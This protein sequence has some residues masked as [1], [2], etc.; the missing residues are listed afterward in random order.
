MSEE[1][2]F[3]LRTS[4]SLPRNTLP[5][6]GAATP[7]RE[8]PVARLLSASKRLCVIVAAASLFSFFAG[9]QPSF[10]QVDVT[11]YHYDNLRTGWNNAETTLTTS[12]VAAH[13]GASQSFNLLHSVALDEQVDAQPL[14]VSD[15]SIAGQSGTYEVVYVA[16]ENN[17]VYAID[18]AS[19][20]VLLSK[21]FGPPVPMSMLPGGCNNNGAS[22]GINSTP[23][24]DLHSGTLYVITYT[25]E[26]NQ[27]VFRLHALDLSSLDD[28]VSPA[29]AITAS[30]QLTD[31]SIYH[32]TPGS[33][34]QRSALLLAN[35]NVYA[36]FASFCDVNG[37][38]SRGWVLGWRKGT[39]TPLAHAALN[40]HLASSTHNFFLSSVW[41]SGYGV[42]SDRSGNLYF[43]TG[44]S[45]YSGTSYDPVKNLSESVVKMSGDLSAVQSYFTPWNVM[46]LD[47]QDLDVGSAGLMV[48]PQQRGTIN[49]LVVAESKS[50]QMYLLNGS[51]LG[52][53]ASPPGPDKILGAYTTGQCWCGPSYFVGADG[54]ARVVSGGGIFS[55]G[56]SA[57]GGTNTENDVI[58]WRL[59]TS[60]T[61]GLVEEHKSV[62]P[63]TS[64]DPGSLTTVS[65]NRRE[66]GTAIVW[67]VAR[68]SPGDSARKVTL[69]AFDASSGATLA[70]AAAGTWPNL[71]G[72]ANIVPV[73]ANGQVYVAS[74]KQLAIFGL[75]TSGAAI[76]A[77]TAAVVKTPGHQLFGTIRSID[78]ERFALETRTGQSVTVDASKAMQ[79]HKSVPPVVNSNVLV[80]GDYDASGVL[81]ANTILHAKRS[82]SWGPDQ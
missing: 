11:T 26:S 49:P 47:Q 24:V 82:S 32:F 74:Y 17:T 19:G 62:L 4:Q 46:N 28:K 2:Y 8:R 60:P 7:T 14:L 76:V 41:M 71:G 80:R 20:R 59:Q 54:Q 56:T 38:L 43:S 52:G 55:G 30:Q 51:S 37:H 69:Y 66:P 1:R 48:L 29:P 81:Q 63:P 10:A 67:T 21:N 75:G 15:E 64:Q 36:G 57:G 61:V 53:H 18:A 70:T 23:V 33:S 73:V 50:G 13:S 42:A 16:T 78:G 12:N 9:V 31:G 5:R 34:R 79:E 65:S 58:V 22:V 39:L 3:R 25:L 40:N 35:G 45:D 44:N 27:P 72:N 6:A 77:R 68:P